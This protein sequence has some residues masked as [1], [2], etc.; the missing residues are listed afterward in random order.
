M[1]DLGP[2]A[3]GGNKEVFL[4]RDFSKERDFSEATAAR[5]DRTILKILDKAYLDTKELLT[6][7][8]NILDAITEALV[9]RETLNGK[10]LDEI[11]IRV[12]GKDILPKRVEVKEPVKRAAKEPARPKPEKGGKGIKDIPPGDVVPGTA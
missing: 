3:F 11:I 12:G 5:I 1:S 2:V 9:E 8:R 7:H 4:G 10:E 6:N